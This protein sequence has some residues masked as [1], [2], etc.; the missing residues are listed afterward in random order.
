MP[1]S[2][3]LFG[4][5]SLIP[6]RPFQHPRPYNRVVTDVMLHWFSSA[7]TAG[8]IL[9]DPPVS[10]LAPFSAFLRQGIRCA[11]EL[12]GPAPSADQDLPEA[13][14]PGHPGARPSS[15]ARIAMQ[16]CGEHYAETYKALQGPSQPDLPHHQPAP[17]A[18]AHIT[19][20]DPALL[21]TVS[22]GGGPTG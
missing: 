17:P 18:A 15:A 3:L 22:R 19:A 2:G 10:G 11:I 8:Q 14:F 4:W 9:H 21:D 7:V 1:R 5:W 16:D 20:D 13:V 12:L 6:A